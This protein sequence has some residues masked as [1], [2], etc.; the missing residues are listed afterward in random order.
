MHA[1]ARV[2][3]PD[4]PTVTRP[5]SS[6]V[7]DPDTLDRAARAALIDELYASHSRIFGGVDRAEFARYVVDSPA[8]WTRIFVLRDTDGVARG[9]TAFHCFDVTHEGE[10]ICVVRMEAGFEPA[11]RNGTVYGLFAM[12]CFARARM[13]AGLRPM[14]FLCSPIHP[15]SYVTIARHADQVWTVPGA[16]AATGRFITGLARTLGMKPVEGRSGVYHIGWITRPSPAPRRIS[17]EAA[18]YLEANPSYAEGHG[19]LTV[20][21]VTAS[22]IIGGV[23]RLLRR[24]LRRMMGAR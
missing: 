14:Y 17:D 18:F 22:G 2:N 8:R 16:D 1:I 23:A 19:L 6:E 5:P 21:P 4:L 24:R 10:A 13:H 11:F 3:T 7:I 15:S 9:Y 20:V 12:R